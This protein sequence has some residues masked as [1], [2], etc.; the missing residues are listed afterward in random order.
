MPILTKNETPAKGQKAEFQLDK[1][2]LAAVTSVAADSYFS[3]SSNWKSVDMI[4]K[5]NI[6][7]QRLVI[8]FNAAQA[9]PAADFFITNKARDVFNIEKIIINDFDGDYFEIPRSALNVVE[10]D[11]SLTSLSEDNYILLENLEELLFEDG[12]NALLD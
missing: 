3:D 2:A 11:V 7:G 10:F 12:T 4:Y 8:K 5:S 9:I 1:A 6:G